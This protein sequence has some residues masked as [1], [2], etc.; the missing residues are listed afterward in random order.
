M[1][2]KAQ[3][4]AWLKRIYKALGPCPVCGKKKWWLNDVPLYGFCW[5]TDAKP[6]EE[7][8][9]LVPKPHNPYL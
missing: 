2:T 8:R 7:V 4:D 5:G 6:H 1:P 3:G 9:K